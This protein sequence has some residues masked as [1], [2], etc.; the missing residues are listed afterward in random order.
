MLVDIV[1]ASANATPGLG[2]YP[3]FKREVLYLVSANCILILHDFAS[4]N[5]RLTIMFLSRLFLLPR[6]PWRVLRMMQRRWWL[7]LL[8]WSG[9]LFHH[10]ISS[11]W[12]REG[13]PSLFSGPQILTFSNLNETVLYML[14]RQYKHILYMTLFYLRIL[15]KVLKCIR[16]FFLA[17][18]LCPLLLS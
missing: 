3:N 10:N 1:S 13:I 6:L 15:V 4:Q 18:W 17:L 12:S 9:Y 7:L 11:D 14:Y 16:E 2:R 5:F 8:T